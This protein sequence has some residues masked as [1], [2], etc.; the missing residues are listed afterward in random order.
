[1]GVRDLTTQAAEN[2]L[3][4]LW[5]QPTKDRVILEYLLLKKPMYKWPCAGQT[6]AVQGSTVVFSTNAAGTTGYP[7]TKSVCLDP[8]FAA[9]TKL[10]QNGLKTYR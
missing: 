10:I 3:L 2:V 7:L 5:S 8:Y 4:H 1:M 9:Y 6:H